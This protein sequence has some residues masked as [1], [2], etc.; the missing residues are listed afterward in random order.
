MLPK[1]VSIKQIQALDRMAMEDYNISSLVLMENAGRLVFSEV[2]SI[3]KNPKKANVC[4]FCGSGNN[5][6]DGLVVARYL[7][8]A[9]IS[10]SVF[11]IGSEK[12][13]KENVCVNLQILKKR[14]DHVLFEI[15]CFNDL[16]AE[17]LAKSEIVVDAIFGV[18][19]NRDIL[20]PHKGIIQAINESNQRVVSVDIPSGLNGDTGEIF[21]VCIK[22]YQTVTFSFAKEGF[23]CN[24]G[25]QYAGMIKIGD[26][27]IPKSA[28]EK[29]LLFSQR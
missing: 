27:G 18:G 7:L 24:Q 1:K 4:I 16:A 13:L 3:I 19:L 12:K 6:G 29:I 10:S 23:Y 17:H 25:P 28:K 20:P 8:E 22:A 15:D 11:I 2:V 14:N 26:I 21:G 9:G 5:A